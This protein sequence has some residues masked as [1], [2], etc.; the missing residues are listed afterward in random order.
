MTRAP[1]VWC[2][3]SPGFGGSERSLMRAMELAGTDGA[4]VVRGE[5]LSPE[6]DRFFA[7]R[8]LPVDGPIGH[9]DARAAPRSLW[10]AL[11]L[12]RRFRDERFVIWAHH[13]DS[14]RWLQ[15]ALALTGRAFL[16]VERGVPSER[17]AV[18]RRS[19]LVMPVKRLV[20]PRARRVIVNA[21]SLM[22]HYR[23]LVG[24][25]VALEVVPGTR[26]V[27]AIGERVAALRAEPGLRERLGLPSGPLVACVARLDR[28]KDLAT[29]VRALAPL[30]ASLVL[31]GEGDERLALEVLAS[32]LMPE[33][34]HI[35]GEQA[36]P[37]PWLAAA[38][39]F[40]LPSRLEGLSRAL[41]EAM[42]AGLPCVASDIPGNRELV[43]DGETGLLF[44][45]GDTQAL[46]EQLAR[47][48]SD[49]AL[50]SRLAAAGRA[51]AEREHDEAIERAAWPRLLDELRA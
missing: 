18:M 41:I 48:L 31:I 30:D 50:A 20:A 22:D 5:S 29:L 37:L 35:V 42:A 36:D 39:A 7:A 46:G 14:H 33:R 32:G 38:D 51:L 17:E 24:V 1:I 23:A 44:A 40:A 9:N 21:R 6:L 28:D 19:K 49:G 26:P 15:V 25:D 4:R 13:F 10:R 47:V 12:L 11:R 3:D 27:R 2:V 34:V 45:V 43:R 16:L 8:G